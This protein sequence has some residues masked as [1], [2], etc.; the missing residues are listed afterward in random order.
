MSI[1]VN[2]KPARGR[3]DIVLDQIFNFPFPLSKPKCETCPVL[4]VTGDWRHF[5]CP[6]MNSQQ[7]LINM[8][9]ENQ[10]HKSQQPKA[11][12][13][14][15]WNKHQVLAGIIL[16]FNL[17]DMKT[18]TKVVKWEYWMDSQSVN[19]LPIWS[20]DIK[21]RLCTLISHSIQLPNP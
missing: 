8:I 7:D 4:T 10:A 18:T 14:F 13:V 2:S 1:T 6:V 3:G 5:K 16:Q 20:P 11:K 15:H 12:Q 21:R 17:Q 9:T 19:G